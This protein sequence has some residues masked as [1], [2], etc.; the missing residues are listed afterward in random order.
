MPTG[1]DYCEKCLGS[2]LLPFIK[3]DGTVSYYSDKLHLPI[4]RSLKFLY[5]FSFS[6]ENKTM[7]HIR[8]GNKITKTIIIFDTIQMMNYPTFWQQ[9]AICFFP[10]QSM[11]QRISMPVSLW[12]CRQI[13]KNITSSSSKSSA[14]PVGV[15]CRKPNN[16]TMQ[17][18]AF[19]TSIR[20]SFNLCA[21]INTIEVLY[22][23]FVVTSR[24]SL[25]ILRT[26]FSAITTRMIVSINFHIGNIL[27]KPVTCQ[28][29]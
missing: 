12:V 9:S 6:L 24:A 29:F 1:K 25:T 21:A 18:T 23:R 11:F 27:Y 8:Q 5:S 20:S 16:R 10:N 15:L 19:F 2:G 28:L 26:R 22:T 17:L 4:K 3:P 7:F 14:F 13:N